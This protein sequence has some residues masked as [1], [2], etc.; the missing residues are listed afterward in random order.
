MGLKWRARAKVMNL[1]GEKILPFGREVLFQALEDPE[2]LVRAVPGAKELVPEGEGRYRA[3]MELSLGP[4]RGRFQGR[5]F[6]R[7]RRPPEGLTLGLEVQSPMGRA[8]GE[9]RVELLPEGGATRLRYEGE[10][11]LM[12]AL[13]GL[14]AR[15]LQG[16]AQN[17][18]EQF[19]KNLEAELGR[20]YGKGADP[21]QGERG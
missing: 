8:E 14:G 6:I 15:L 19:F 1:Q 13:A 20:R 5:V 3:V 2:V 11:R 10:A 17:L 16:A 9:G 21:D 12:G 18:A 4:L 7:D